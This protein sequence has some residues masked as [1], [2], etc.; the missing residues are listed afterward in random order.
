[1]K[2]YNHLNLKMRK[3]IYQLWLRGL[4]IRAIARLIGRDASTV[5]R[6]IRRN[7]DDIGYLP[8]TAHIKYQK[9][10]FHRKKKILN[11]A[12][13]TEYIIEKIRMHWSPEQ[14]SGRMKLDEMPFYASTETIYQFIYSDAGKALMLYPFLRYSQSKRGQLYGRK[15]RSQNIKDRVSIHERPP[16][17][18]TRLEIGHFEG[19]LTFFHGNRSANLT[20]LAERFSRLTVL[21]KNQSKQT[22]DV[23]GKIL[24]RVR[25]VPMKSITFDNGSEFSAH[26]R[27]RQEYNL[28]TYFC[29]PGSPWQKGTVENSISRLHRFIPKNSDLSDWSNTEI[30]RIEAKINSIPRKTLGFLTPF[31]V[32]Y[33]KYQSV[34]LH[35]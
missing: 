8:D 4:G 2:E 33:G 23:I 31:E 25:G 14:I 24:E 18:D 30:G 5:S 11:A 6:E 20:V 29:D 35:S 9:R 16:T 34:A 32:F 26:T 19:D 15:I 12:M 3:E 27:L 21:I 17:I 28:A 7:I 13:L 22:D 10:R 1:M